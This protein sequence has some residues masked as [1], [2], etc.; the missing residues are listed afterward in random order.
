MNPKF[1]I[2]KGIQTFQLATTVGHQ[3]WAQYA[4]QTSDNYYK[5]SLPTLSSQIHASLCG[6]DQPFSLG[7]KIRNGWAHQIQMVSN[8]FQF[9]PNV[10]SPILQCEKH[11]KE[12]YHSQR[13]KDE[14]FH[15]HNHNFHISSYSVGENRTRNKL[16]AIHSKALVIHCGHSFN[17]ANHG[18]YGAET[19]YKTWQTRAPYLI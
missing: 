1:T 5:S 4:K 12:A 8:L 10:I 9:F 19:L 3:S 6:L 11:H 13:S 15:R 16:L 2:W 14:L 7:T 17:S 18:A